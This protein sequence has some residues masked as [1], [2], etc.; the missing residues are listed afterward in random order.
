MHIDRER[1]IERFSCVHI[2][3]YSPSIQ[4]NCKVYIRPNLLTLEAV[5]VTTNFARCDVILSGIRSC[6]GRLQAM[7]H[8]DSPGFTPI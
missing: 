3:T 8:E 7:R 5:I 4:I 6:I 2:C 1:E